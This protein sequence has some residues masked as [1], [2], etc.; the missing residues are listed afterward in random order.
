MN[1][2]SWPLIDPDDDIP[3][4]AKQ[5]F[6][7]RFLSS[8]GDT[9]FLKMTFGELLRELADFFAQNS[10]SDFPVTDNSLDF[11]STSRAGVEVA[12]TYNSRAEVLSA[13]KDYL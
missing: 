7:D 12:M 3:Q 8:S 13:A 5:A 11:D 1:V 10:Y 9:I 4:D 2:K 6:Q